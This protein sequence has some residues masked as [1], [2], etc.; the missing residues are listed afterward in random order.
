MTH[1]RAV[2]S[3]ALLVSLIAIAGCGPRSQAPADTTADE[4]ALKADPEN[5]FRAYIAGDADAVA[6]L[7]A[8]DGFLM[9]PG[10]AALKGRAAIREFIAAD[11]AQTKAA[12]L[13]LSLDEI[14]GVGVAGDTGW[15]S[16]TFT[17]KNASGG[18]VDHG[19]FLSVYRKSAEGWKLLRDTWNMDSAPAQVSPAGEGD[20]SAAP[21]QG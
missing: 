6:A 3:A 20:G 2:L 17:M 11:S 13:T 1:R 9:P 18:D 15:L 10:A 19:K 14:T 21:Q 4:A 16:G 7:Y 8:E 12:G 5:W